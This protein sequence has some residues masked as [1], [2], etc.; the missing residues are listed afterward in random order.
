M[1]TVTKMDRALVAQRDIYCY[2]VMY[3]HCDR[4]RG[5]ME[6]LSPV[7]YT[8]YMCETEMTLR[9]AEL[10]ARENPD[11]GRPYSLKHG[12]HSFSS[13][14]ALA[15][16]SVFDER[17]FVV[18]KCVIPRGSLYWKGA[19]R[20]GERDTFYCS[21]RIK[22]IAWMRPEEGKWMRAKENY[23]KPAGNPRM[24]VLNGLTLDEA[25]DM[26]S[27]RYEM[28]CFWGDR[29]KGRFWFGAEGRNVPYVWLEINH[30]IV[31][32]QW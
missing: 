3:Q 30:G 9:E 32:G 6:F 21:D 25:Q 12:F 19:G 18:V 20:H 5:V 28:H 1:C 8:K 31:T 11:T 7:F 14:D 22:L 15:R 10:F 13:L 4:T 23:T 17:D 27:E 26:L 24:S 16:E 29:S 2:K